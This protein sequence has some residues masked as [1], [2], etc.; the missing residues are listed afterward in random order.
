MVQTNPNQKK[1]IPVI[2]ISNKIKGIMII[3]VKIIQ[4]YVVLNMSASNNL[5]SNFIQH[6]FI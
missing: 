2:L 4:E 6:K 5:Y 1:A 3:K